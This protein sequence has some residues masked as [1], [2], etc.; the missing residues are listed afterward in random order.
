MKLRK[1]KDFL[2]K[3]DIKLYDSQY[4]IITSIINNRNIQQGGGQ[5]CKLYNILGNN[6]IQIKN[7]ISKILEF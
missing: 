2:N 7:K 3:Y 4:R 6:T 5:N 1:L